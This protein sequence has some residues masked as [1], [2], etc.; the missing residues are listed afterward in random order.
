M[1]SADDLDVDVHVCGFAHDVLQEPFVFQN[2]KSSF[3]DELAA[4]HGNEEEDRMVYGTDFLGEIGDVADLAPVPI[5]HGRV[6]L[7]GGPALLQASMPAP[8]AGEVSS[9]MWP[10][11]E[12][13][14]EL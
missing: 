1:G 4:S 10:A 6:N 8:P 2:L 9:L 5:D 13:A 3:L 11:Y 7:E 14:N 12:L